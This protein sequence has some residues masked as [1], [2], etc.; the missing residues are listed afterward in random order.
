[1]YLERRL[2][3]AIKKKLFRGRVDVFSEIEIRDDT[4]VP[5]TRLNKARLSQIIEISGQMQ[6][7]DEVGGQLDVNSLIK[8]PDLIGAQRVGFR[9]PEELEA[10]IESTLV[11]ALDRVGQSRFQEGEKLHKDILQRLQAAGQCVNEVE[12]AC[13][14]RQQEMRDQI[15]KRVQ[16][17]LGD[18]QLDP[19][20]LMAEVVFNADRLDISEEITRLKAHLS[21]AESLLSSKKRPLGKE[22]DFLMQEL[23]RE[24]T[25]IGNKAKNEW[26]AK[27]VVR[28]KTSF[29]KIRE[30]IQNL[31]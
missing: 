5:P 10:L 26:I 11:E 24:V 13:L 22:L 18:V 21:T 4:L 25:T 1:M 6:E 29:E 8:L 17:L 12:Q 28:F 19:S 14:E 3:T 15:E 7:R 2:R 30:Q 9:L 16:V 20:R 31:E 27:Y 23:M